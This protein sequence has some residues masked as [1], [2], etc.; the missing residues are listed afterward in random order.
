MGEL[1]KNPKKFWSHLKTFRKIGSKYGNYVSM[2]KWVEHFENLN[3]RDPAINPINFLRC[4][5]I[6]QEVNTLINRLPNENL[7]PDKLIS[8]VSF[9]E[10]REFMKNLKSGKASGNDSICNEMIILTKDII[11]LTV[12]NLF[13]KIIELEYFPNSWSLSL[14]VPIHKSGELDDPNNFRG[15]SLNS[16]LS[17]LFT[18]IMNSR[19]MDTCEE[20]ELIDDNQIGFRKGFRTADHVFTLKTLIDQSFK[21]KNKLYSCFVDFKKAYDTV[22]R[23]GLMYKM[24]E[25]GLNSKFVR[26]IQNI[27]SK[28]KPCVQLESGLSHSFDSSVGL[29]QGCNLSPTLFNIFVNDLIH[30][31]NQS[32]SDAPYL[33]NVKVSCLLY[34]D[35]LVLISKS[36]EGLQNSL[37]ALDKFTKDWFL[38]VNPKKT[39][40][41]VFSKTKSKEIIENFKLGETLLNFCSEYCYLGVLFSERGSFNVATKALNDKAKGSMFSLLRDINRQ[42]ACRPDI[43]LDLFDR[44][45]KPIALY[46]AEIWGYSC[47]PTNVKNLDLLNFKFISKLPSENLHHKF[48]KTILGVGKLTSHWGIMNETGRYPLILDIFNYMINFFYHLITS[49]SELILSAL[50]VN[51]NLSKIGVNTWYKSL[52]RILKFFNIEHLMYTSDFNEIAS[53]IYK[54]KNTLRKKYDEIW[55]SE[56]A[57]WKEKSSKIEFLLHLKKDFKM[58]KYLKNADLLPSHRIAISKIRLSSTKFPIEIGRYENVP[59]EQRICHFG[60]DKIGNE[61]HY[62]FNCNQ[63]FIKKLRDNLKLPTNGFESEQFCRNWLSDLFESNEQVKLRIF[64]AHTARVLATYKELI[65]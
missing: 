4:I 58:A 25:K 65:G 53:Q 43:L 22:W 61:I 55:E 48:I 8:K 10:V 37:N 18:N 30:Y 5:G 9:F 56:K 36:K 50:Y 52:I 26:L 13:S 32:N 59:R 27:Y 23:N 33:G 24:L 39:K 1:S 38:E 42:H 7:F 21:R 12:A 57:E 64:G 15:I 40:C 19:L 29:K 45:I 2:E 41:L 44:I 47:I 49:K 16:C 34:A 35:D 63:P 11:G 46:N 20:R 60:C 6:K 14:I 31:V 17:K 3:S 62:L 51:K 54:L 28:T